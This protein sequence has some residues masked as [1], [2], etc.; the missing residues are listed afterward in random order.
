MAIRTARFLFLLTHELGHIVG[1]A[2]CGGSLKSADLLSWHPPHTTNNSPFHRHLRH[3]C[4]HKII[5]GHQQVALLA[6]IEW[7]NRGQPEM[8]IVFLGQRDHIVNPKKA[9]DVCTVPIATQR[10]EPDPVAYST[11]D[12]YLIGKQSD[13]REVLG[14]AFGLA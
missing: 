2:C 12:K 11:P 13:G 6:R 4:F 5:L 1:G 3:S 10:K 8:F 14:R 9:R 7:D